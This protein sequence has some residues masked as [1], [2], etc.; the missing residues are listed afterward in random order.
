[1]FAEINGEKLYYE[2]DGQ[3]PPLA[4]IHGWTL[5]LRMWDPQAPTLSRRFQVIRFDRRGFG[6]SKC[7]LNGYSDRSSRREY[8]HT[9][10]GEVG[11]DNG[12]QSPCDSRTKFLPRF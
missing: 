10:A 12:T 2:Q 6:R 1:M 9:P 5:S 11:V 4:L 8:D 7:R 3:G